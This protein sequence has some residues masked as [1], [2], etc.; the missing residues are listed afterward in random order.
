MEMSSRF[1][2]QAYRILRKGVY[3][4]LSSR[5][6]VYATGWFLQ[7][8]P[9]DEAEDL[10][11]M[12][13]FDNFSSKG[14]IVKGFKNKTSTLDCTDEDGGLS[15]VPNDS[16]TVNQKVY[17][18]KKDQATIFHVNVSFALQLHLVHSKNKLQAKYSMYI[19]LQQ[20]T[21]GSCLFGQMATSTAS[22]SSAPGVKSAPNYLTN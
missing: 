18:C 12:C 7:S 8:K 15:C 17:I 10:D 14:V 13:A 20:I 11:E 22:T 2:L 6:N 1:K 21:Q 9:F 4:P 3:T 16:Q 19:L 5:I